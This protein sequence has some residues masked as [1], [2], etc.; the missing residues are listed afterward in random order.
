MSQLKRLMEW[1]SSNCNGDW[2]HS[3]G[4]KIETLDNPGWSITVDFDGAD[5]RFDPGVERF[6]IERVEDEDCV[7]FWYDKDRDRLRIFCGKDNL[8]EALKTFL[9]QLD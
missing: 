2:E 5:H 3:G 4:V 9:D 7:Q 6:N 1:Y 8:E